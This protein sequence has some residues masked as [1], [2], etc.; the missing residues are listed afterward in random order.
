MR[1]PCALEAIARV[2]DEVDDVVV[3]AG[4][5][6]RPEQI[7]ELSRLGVSFAATPGW[8]PELLDALAA[9]RMPALP[10]VSTVSEAMVLRDRGFSVLKLFPARIL[11]G[12]AFLRSLHPVLPDVRFCP[13]GGI[14]DEQIVEYA[15]LPNVIS[16]GGTWLC[17][18]EVVMARDWDHV[19]RLAR[20]A[21][22]RAGRFAPGLEPSSTEAKPHAHRH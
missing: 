19:T 10:G 14:R 8:T 16:L 2:I 11:G 12:I 18:R 17:P 20:F 15:A 21:R 1:T 9:A 4:T 22:A 13:T 3:G 6:T 5:V 7:D